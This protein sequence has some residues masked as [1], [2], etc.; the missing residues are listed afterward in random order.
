MIVALTPCNGSK[1]Q[2]LK[3]EISH[4]FTAKSHNNFLM[5]SSLCN[6]YF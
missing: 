2:L 5:Y 4:T 1:V 3:I 6:I